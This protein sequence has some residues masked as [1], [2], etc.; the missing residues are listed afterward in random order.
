MKWENNDLVLKVHDEVKG[1][2]LDDTNSVRPCS[3]GGE[4]PVKES[5]EVKSSYRLREMNDFC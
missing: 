3:S 2:P 4:R 5:D 1:L